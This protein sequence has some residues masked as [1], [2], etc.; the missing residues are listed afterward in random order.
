MGHTNSVQSLNNT[1]DTLSSS[2]NTSIGFYLREVTVSTQEI[3]EPNLALQHHHV[4][5][6]K[7]E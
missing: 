2:W 5:S 3:Y 4:Q 7:N 1:D 6:S